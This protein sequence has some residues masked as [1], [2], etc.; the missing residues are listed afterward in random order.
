MQRLRAPEQADMLTIRQSQI[1][2]LQCPTQA[3]FETQMLSHLERHYPADRCLLGTD[4]LLTVVRAGQVEGLRLGLVAQGDMRRFITMR[5]VLGS[6]VLRDPMLP[7]AIELA[8]ELSRSGALARLQ[9]QAEEYLELANGT[10]GRKALRAMLRAVALPFEVAMRI[11]GHDAHAGILRLLRRLWP[12]RFRL[13]PIESRGMFL[14]AA[15]QSA[16]VN[17]LD[18]PGTAQLHTV[19]MFLLGAEYTADPALPWAGEA[20]AGVL[21]GSAEV[22]ARA[23]YDAGQTAVERLRQVLAAEAG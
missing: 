11:E 5:L 18:T 2:A 23:L 10:D 9:A 7:W 8:P 3:Q 17:G 1:E 6:G 19:L 20:L 13:L 14:Q 15:A 21:D 4:G 12:E 16:R 22:R